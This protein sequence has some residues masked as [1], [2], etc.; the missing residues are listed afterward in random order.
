MR[1]VSSTEA[2][3]NSAAFYDIN[4]EM[5]EENHLMPAKKGRTRVYHETKPQVSLRS[6]STACHRVWCGTETMTSNHENM[7][8]HTVIT[9]SRILGEYFRVLVLLDRGAMNSTRR[10]SNRGQT[11]FFGKI[12]NVMLVT[13]YTCDTIGCNS[14]SLAVRGWIILSSVLD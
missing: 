10:T 1:S 7:D 2:C 9:E 12:L 8:E 4:C 6:D 14:L 13:A 11:R 5:T 3:S